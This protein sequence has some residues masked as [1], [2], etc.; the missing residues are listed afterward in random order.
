MIFKVGLY[1]WFIIE[2]LID[3]HEVNWDRKTYFKL[4]IGLT[5]WF[6]VAFW[7]YKI[8]YQDYKVFQIW[9]KLYGASRQWWACYFF[10]GKIYT[11]WNHFVSNIYINSL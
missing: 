1:N 4:I 11:N 6:N 10:K 7:F 8:P 9:G 2:I 3:K 5:K